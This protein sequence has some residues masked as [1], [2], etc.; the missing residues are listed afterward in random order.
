MPLSKGRVVDDSLV[1]CYHG[2]AYDSTGA[3]IH[4][5]RQT[6][7]LSGL[8]VR[9]YPAIERYGAVWVWM[10][11]PKRTDQSTIF[12]CGLLDPNGHDG[13]R[14]YF[15]VNANYGFINDNLADLLHIGFL[16][17]PAHRNGSSVVGASDIG[18][19]E[20]PNGRIE[21]RQEGNCI[22]GDWSWSAIT[23][24]PT[25]KSLAGIIGRAD[26]WV[27]SRFHP[28]SFFVNPIGFAEAGTG[29]MESNLEQ[30]KGKFSFTLYQCIT[31][32]TDRTT[33][34]FKLLAHTWTPEMVEK[35]F[36][37]VN[38]VNTEDIWAMEL[39][40]QALDR[41][42]HAQ[43][44]YIHTDGAVVRVHRLLDKLLQEEAGAV[45]GLSF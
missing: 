44:R 36:Q 41:N 10:G 6:T 7:P 20:L 12:D 14:I 29:A 18:N 1:C 17:N 25:F 39:Q 35:G 42:P 23:P 9:S 28:P 37:L 33:H 34:F 15:H 22:Y 16:H 32:E 38:K 26:G 27:L 5:P 19:D 3:C 30:G 31:P 45:A 40:Q 8:C 24:P 21:V 2:L 43:M 13:T 4:V 11:D